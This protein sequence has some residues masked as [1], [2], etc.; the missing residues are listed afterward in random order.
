MILGGLL[1]ALLAVPALFIFEG[2]T[3]AN[4]VFLSRQ[5]WYEVMADPAVYDA[6]VGQLSAAAPEREALLAALSPAYVQ[7]QLN[8]LV[9]YSFEVL[10]GVDTDKLTF[11]VPAALAATL[12]QDPNLT[13]LDVVEGA[14]GALQ[15]SVSVSERSLSQVRGL[16]SQYNLALLFSAGIGLGTWF[17]AAW[18][19]VEGRRARLMWLGSG[20]LLAS[21]GVLLVGLIFDNAFMPV[22]SDRLIRGSADS[23]ALTRAIL[24]GLKDV[25]PRFGTGL[26][27][28][29]GI[30]FAI[31]LILFVS[32]AVMRPR[33]Q[34]ITRYP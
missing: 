11:D 7:S 1:M 14:D 31:G 25:L 5:T 10:N 33:K 15:L 30:P 28:A 27:V 19:A 22:V 13:Y 6:A 29:G 20:L 21:M 2:M 3:A 9:D 18:L 34:D 17:V 23:D 24:H 4:S 26:I 16:A 12:R 8:R 32:G